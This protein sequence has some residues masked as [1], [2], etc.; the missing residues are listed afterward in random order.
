MKSFS[1]GTVIELMKARKIK[2]CIEV[3][4]RIRG[5]KALGGGKSGTETAK[6]PLF[7]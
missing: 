1:N 6:A 5:G 4:K 2:K 7:V 3:I